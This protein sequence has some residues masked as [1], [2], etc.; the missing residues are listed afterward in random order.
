MAGESLVELSKAFPSIGAL[1][2]MQSALKPM[3]S[4]LK[5]MQSAFER[6]AKGRKMGAPRKP[7]GVFPTPN[8][9]RANKAGLLVNQYRTPLAAMAAG[10]AAG[11]GAGYLA[12]RKKD[13]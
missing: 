1:K 8:Q 7:T 6:G 3:Q 5:P 11:A 4:A 10:G 9:I 2:P 13:D 12:G